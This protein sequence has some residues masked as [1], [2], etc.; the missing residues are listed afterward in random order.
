MV[1]GRCGN[2]P[3]PYRETRINL[4]VWHPGTG[5]GARFPPAGIESSRSCS[6][7]GAP[8]GQW[9][10]PGACSPLPLGG[11]GTVLGVVLG[12]ALAPGWAPHSRELQPGSWSA[13]EEGDAL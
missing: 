11:G 1:F 9:G 3:I 2:E 12:F 7:P 13:L 5:G 4:Q 8:Q 6:A 10:D